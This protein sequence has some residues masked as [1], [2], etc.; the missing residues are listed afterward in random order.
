[1]KIISYPNIVNLIEVINDP[2]TDHFYMV[3]Y[4]EGKWD[5][6][7]VGPPG[8][9][10]EAIM[11]QY[12]RDIVSGLMY[13]HSHN[14]VHMDIKTQNLLVSRNGT[15]KIANFSVSQVF[16]MESCFLKLIECSELEDILYG[17]YCQSIN[18]KITCKSSG[19]VSLLFTYTCISCFISRE[20]PVLTFFITV[21]PSSPFLRLLSLLEIPYLNSK[22]PLV[23]I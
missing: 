11:R 7:G 3:E 2:D 1:M 5:C 12:L 23:N 10:G 13:L 22:F 8:G 6:E 14:I 9:L 15:V 21:F 4:V 16:E 18:L 20:L 19:N 17:Q